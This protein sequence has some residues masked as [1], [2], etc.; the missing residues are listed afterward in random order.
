MNENQFFKGF[1]YGAVFGVF[2]YI[3]VLPY[4]FPSIRSAKWLDSFLFA[5]PFLGSLPL[6]GYSIDQWLYKR[7][8]IHFYDELY[9]N[10]DKDI[11]F[12]DF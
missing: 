6:I 4:I 12:Y 3:F 8:K 11:D 1:T 9:P 5:L 2:I 7:K 10:L